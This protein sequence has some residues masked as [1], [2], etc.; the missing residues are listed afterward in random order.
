MPCGDHQVAGAQ[1]DPSGSLDDQ[2]AGALGDPSGSL[3]DRV[4][5][6][7]DEQRGW[8]VRHQS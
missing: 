7:P 5:V 6:E 3:D 1:G 2:A 4:A 8:R